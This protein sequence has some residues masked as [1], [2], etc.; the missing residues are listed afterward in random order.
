IKGYMDVNEGQL[1]SVKSLNGYKVFRNWTLLGTVT[2]TEYID[3]NAPYEN[4]FYCVRA[5]YDVCE[6][7][8]VCVEV[9]LH[10]GLPDND[11]QGI[12]IYPNPASD[13]VN[14]E[15]SQAFSH[16]DVYNYLGLIVYSSDL[17]GKKP[18]KL[19]TTGYPAGTYLVRFVNSEGN[20]FTKRI[21]IDK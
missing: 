14:I 8:D 1:K 9:S 4:N 7:P 13:L 12:K 16:L 20:T 18:I 21:V 11:L 19:N 15:V 17:S 6:S 5:V 10:V 3:L 2:E